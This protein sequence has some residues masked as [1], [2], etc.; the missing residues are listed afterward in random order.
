M[1]EM[2]RLNLLNQLLIFEITRVGFLSLKDK[3][4]LSGVCKELYRKIHYKNASG[5]HIC[6]KT[7]NL[8]HVLIRS[9]S[10]NKKLF[11]ISILIKSVTDINSQ[12]KKGR[13]AL[14]MATK[15]G[16]TEIVK[17]LLEQKDLRVNLRN[18]RGNSALLL[19]AWNNY[20]E[21]VKLLL[22]NTFVPN[23]N[24]NLQNIHGDT[25]L[26][27]ASRWGYTGI[28]KLL[29]GRKDLNI[30]L[31]DN[32]GYTAL[33]EASRH[34]RTKIVKLLLGNAFVP[35]IKV[36]LRNKNGNTALILASR[37][38]CIEIVELLLGE[39]DIKIDYT[40]NMGV[41]AATEA[42]NFCNTKICELLEKYGRT[43]SRGRR[44]PQLRS[45]VMI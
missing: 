24:V 8:G 43:R 10:R 14:M 38:D 21:V 39:K 20:L 26:I 22:T 36:N 45:T 33:I 18:F 35:K 25:A 15:C 23:I 27:F 16:Y 1:K 31:K 42:F 4:R 30:N 9:F 32:S 41:N 3:I 17:Q 19:A 40:N 6:L 12:D 28:V 7:D 37:A 34:G 13:S 5:D 44:F 11:V 29:L 2:K